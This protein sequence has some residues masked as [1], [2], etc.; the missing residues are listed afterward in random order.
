MGGSIR[1]GRIAGIPINLHVSWFII[2]VLSAVFFE[3]YFSN[4]GFLGVDSH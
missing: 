3:R 2:F 4:S 1:L